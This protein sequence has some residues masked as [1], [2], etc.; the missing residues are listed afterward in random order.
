MSPLTDLAAS[1]PITQ[2]LSAREEEDEFDNHVSPILDAASPDALL[3]TRA[4]DSAPKIIPSSDAEEARQ[5]HPNQ[6]LVTPDDFCSDFISFRHGMRTNDPKLPKREL[7]ELLRTYPDGEPSYG[8]TCCICFED[9]CTDS[10]RLVMATLCAKNH[11]CCRACMI[12]LRARHVIYCPI[13]RGS[14]PVE[15]RFYT[16]ND[17]HAVYVLCSSCMLF[18][19]PLKRVPLSSPGAAGSELPLFLQQRCAQCCSL[20]PKVSMMGKIWQLLAPIVIAEPP[21]HAHCNA[22]KILYN[23]FLDR[24][25][26]GI[27]QFQQVK[28]HVLRSTHAL[29]ACVVMLCKQAEFLTLEQARTLISLVLFSGNDYQVWCDAVLLCTKQASELM[30][31]LDTPLARR[32]QREFPEPL[33]SIPYFFVRFHMFLQDVRKRYRPS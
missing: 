9:Q 3:D 26:M 30:T 24:L 1:E 13:C 28:E 5:E 7:T 29:S 31:E 8:D 17:E 15:D 18:P 14:L 4:N 32:L 20:D 23:R 11:V 33:R 16:I 12:Q 6:M 21:E 25:E 22:L 19:A 27:E 2:I 10:G